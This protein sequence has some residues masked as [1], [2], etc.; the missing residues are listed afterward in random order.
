MV[1]LDFSG[2][3]LF[4]TSGNHVHFGAMDSYFIFITTGG[5]GILPDCL[6]HCM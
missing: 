5:G 1:H 4:T 3:M 6:M 2:T